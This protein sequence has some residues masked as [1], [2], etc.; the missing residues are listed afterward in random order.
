[1]IVPTT[2]LEIIQRI[3]NT[4]DHSTSSPVLYSIPT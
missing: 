2:R 4:A 1:M 3:I